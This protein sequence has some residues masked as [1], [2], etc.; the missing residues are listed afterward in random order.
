MTMM[1]MTMGMITA[2]ITIMTTEA[3]LYRLLLW[4]S[5]AYPIGGFSYS[6]GIEAAVE[7]KALR[8][9]ADL[10]DWVETVLL[11]G[12]GAIDAALFTM[13]YRAAESDDAAA[14]NQIADSAEVWR[15][16]EEL[17]LE[18]SQQ[19][20][21]FL[22]ISNSA[23]PS[24]IVQRFTA[25]RGGQAALPVAVAVNAVAHGIPLRAALHGY[26]TGFVANLVSAGL[27]AIPLGQ[28][29]AQI[30]LAKL[31]PA[32]TAAVEAG[33]DITDLDQVGAAAPGLDL[34]SITHETQY[35]RLFRS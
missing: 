26:L 34:F 28:T 33:L 12:A 20:A 21:S 24:P 3:A 32:V 22:A 8:D 4:M 25:E 31:E 2:T 17:A 5:P 13:A 11:G 27:R 23:W 15:G 29:A 35:T 30:A 7:A 10:T 19:G 9:A 6:H 16:T 14:L 1:I 18:S